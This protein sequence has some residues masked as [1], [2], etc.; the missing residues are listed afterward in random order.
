MPIVRQGSQTWEKPKGQ[1]NN[2]LC[3]F[4]KMFIFQPL[5]MG[6]HHRA[7]VYW[8][9][10]IG[11]AGY[12]IRLTG[13]FQIRRGNCF[14]NQVDVCGAMPVSDPAGRRKYG[15][16]GVGQYISAW[17]S[18]VCKQNEDWKYRHLACTITIN[19]KVHQ[20]CCISSQKLSNVLIPLHPPFLKKE[21]KGKKE[22]RHLDLITGW[23]VTS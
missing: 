17:L 20:H 19:S 16:E 18:A 4:N 8:A 9:W 12:R 23:N 5:R 15:E 7:L 10:H 3:I 2:R 13:R 21:K 11:Q 6:T 1:T 14:I 22:K